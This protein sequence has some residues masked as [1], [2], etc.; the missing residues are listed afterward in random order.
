[1]ELLFE[2]GFGDLFV[3]RNAG[4]LST[5]VISAVGPWRRPSILNCG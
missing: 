4:T 5:S 1:L 2:T 3:V